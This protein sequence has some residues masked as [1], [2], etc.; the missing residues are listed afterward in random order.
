[1]KAK[2][3]ELGHGEHER[4]A[5]LFQGLDHQLITAAVLGGAN[6]GRIWVDD[7]AEPG[8]AFMASPEGCF[9]AGY[10]ANDGFNRAVHEQI[11]VPL[12]NKYGIVV[13]ICHPDAWEAVLDVV[14][15]GQPVVMRDRIHYLLDRPRVDWKAEVPDGFDVEPIDAALL[16]RTGLYIPEHVTGWMKSNWGSVAGFMANGLGCCTVH[17]DRIVSWSL[18]DCIVGDACEIGIRTAEEY[19]RQG[20]ATL[21][22]AATVDACL[23]RGVTA[24]GWQCD[25][26]NWGSRKVAE[27]VG[28]V[29]ERNYVHYLCYTEDARNG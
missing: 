23:A 22:A 27:K 14:V 1:M 4:V 20:L 13:L 29:H 15:G 12:Q 16:A 17:G 18:A 2:I 9:L 6:P 3:H 11:V 8:S 25:A 7:V 24:V 5:P 19:R 26:D 21:T 28:F 10:E